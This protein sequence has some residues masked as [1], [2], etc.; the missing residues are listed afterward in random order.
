VGKHLHTILYA[1]DDHDDLFMVRQAFAQFDGSVNLV[2]AQDGYDTIEKLK[3]AQANSSLPCLVILD[4]N[5][6]GMD[7]KETLVRLKQ[8]E[9]F[10]KIPV[11]L[12]TTSSSDIDK[13]F[14]DRWGAR[15]ITKPLVYS[16]LEMLATN[17]LNMCASSVPQTA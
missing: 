10:K 9:A 14:A 12:F 7:G 4:V 2:H 13:A 8:S 11:V 3:Q 6:P 5:M 15:F 17:F 16:E 1:E